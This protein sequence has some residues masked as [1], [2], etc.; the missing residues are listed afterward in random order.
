MARRCDKVPVK[1]SDQCNYKQRKGC[2]CAFFNQGILNH[3]ISDFLTTKL[4]D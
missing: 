4:R 3:I 1:Q 2:A